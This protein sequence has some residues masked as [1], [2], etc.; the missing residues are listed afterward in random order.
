VPEN[1]TDGWAP[2]AVLCGL[3]LLTGLLILL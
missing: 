3:C 1:Q 2:A